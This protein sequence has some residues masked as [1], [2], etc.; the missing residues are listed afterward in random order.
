MSK[1]K[2]ISVKPSLENKPDDA[3]GKT[4]MSE[5]KKKAGKDTAAAVNNTETEQ[6]QL[7]KEQKAAEKLARSIAKEKLRADK[8]A[9]ME[10]KKMEEKKRRQLKKEM[11]AKEKA[12]R[13]M[14]AEIQQHISTKKLAADSAEKKDKSEKPQKVKKDKPKKPEEK[15]L[16]EI[17]SNVQVMREAMMQS[18]QQSELTDC[19]PGVVSI[20]KGMMSTVNVYGW[21]EGALQAE[22]YRARRMAYQSALNDLYINA[23]LQCSI[24]QDMECEAN[25]SCQAVLD[26]RITI[27]EN[28]PEEKIQWQDEQGKHT[29][30]FQFRFVLTAAFNCR[31]RYNY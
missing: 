24:G 26:G 31:C 12:E 27:K 9:A 2:K 25:T 1:A 14:Q 16:L 13:K 18:R 30:I 17:A 6:L 10:L 15:F 5:K 20:G 21:D 29:L 22:K 3:K 23:N 11:K 28:P 8:K 19:A 7:K 4:K